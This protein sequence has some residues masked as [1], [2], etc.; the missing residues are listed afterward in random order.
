MRCSRPHASIR[1]TRRSLREL[2]TSCLDCYAVPFF[3]RYIVVLS[4][5][6]EMLVD[7]QFRFYAV[8]R[9]S[10][11]RNGGRGDVTRAALQRH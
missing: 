8:G 9:T 7:K 6:M 11:S 2:G 4:S 10:F 1:A 5:R 3:G